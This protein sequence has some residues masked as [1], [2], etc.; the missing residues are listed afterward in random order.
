[1]AVRMLRLLG[2]ARMQGH[3]CKNSRITE[4]LQHVI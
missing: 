3:A 2:V 4:L 1:M